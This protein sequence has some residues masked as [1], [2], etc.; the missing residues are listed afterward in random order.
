MKIGGAAAAAATL[1]GA[2]GGLRP[3]AAQ[4]NVTIQWWDHYAP[5]EALLQANFDAYTAANPN[6]TIERTLYNLPELGQSLQ[7]AFNSDQAPDVHA[8]ASLQVPVSRLVTDGWFTPIEDLVTPEFRARFPEGTLLEGVHI[9]DGKLY[10][11]PMFSFRSHTTLL[12]FNKQLM[13]AAG[14]DPENGP[15]TWDEF[16]TA[17]GTLTEAGS[18]RTYGWI[19]AIQLAERL[20]AQ[21]T[22][23]AQTAGA[24]GTIDWATGEYIYHTDPFIQA[25]EFV[26]SIAQDGNL[27]PGSNSLDARN[28]RAR[29]AT[30]VAGMNFDG[31]W[32]IGV[33]NNDYPEFMDVIG[34]SQIPVPD[35]ST[36][37]YIKRGP[38]GGDFWVSSQT[39]HAAI[40]AGILEQFN[41][42]EFYTGLAERMDQPPLD[43]T[44][45]DRANVQPAYAKALGLFNEIVRLGPVPEIKNPAI[46]DVAAKM[47]DIRPNFGEIV[48]GVFSGDIS[49]YKTALK[50]YS[51]K[52]TAE[53]DR[54]IAE[55]AAT[56]AEVSLD[57][58]VFP[59]WDPATDYT[60]EFY[61]DA[62]TPAAG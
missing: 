17:A 62:A 36:P 16:R 34:V 49:D 19:Q 41:T 23:L 61:T 47:T 13:E 24:P 43:L 14:L 22:E 31:P 46:S 51:D 38:T 40:A 52:L 53:R 25:I 8:I 28:A 45:V 56:G 18:G 11:F 15:K 37:A 5:L 10:S 1:G 4:E 39:E 2:G 9:F 42:P 12:W 55:V 57:D 27:F 7:L 44:A 29:F 60:S 48:Q 50:D 54:A 59:N 35:A 26:H 58:W 20:G 21:V 6:V 30:G 3:A 33:M 32:S